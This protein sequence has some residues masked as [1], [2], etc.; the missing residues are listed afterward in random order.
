[1]ACPCEPLPPLDMPLDMPD[2]DRQQ[3]ARSTSARHAI[4]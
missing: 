4:A 2:N 1:M 3:G